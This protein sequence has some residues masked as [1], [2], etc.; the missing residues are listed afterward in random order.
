MIGG[1]CQGRLS[2]KLCSMVGYSFILCECVC[3]VSVIVKH[4]VL[5]PSVVDGRST[6]P[7]YYYYLE[8]KVGAMFV[9][10]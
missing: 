9:N 5:P 2:L 10:A 1:V 7:L 4:P 8:V 6:N 3:V